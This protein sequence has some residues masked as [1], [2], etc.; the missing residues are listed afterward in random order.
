MIV[1]LNQYQK[2]L[3]SGGLKAVRKLPGCF[4]DLPQ[5]VPESPSEAGYHFESLAFDALS[6]GHAGWAAICMGAA[7]EQFRLAKQPE[8]I[9]RSVQQNLLILAEGFPPFEDQSALL[10]AVRTWARLRLALLKSDKTE[11]GTQGLQGVSPFH[12]SVLAHHRWWFSLLRTRHLGQVFKCDSVFDAY[13]ATLLERIILWTS[14]VV[15]GKSGGGIRA[16]LLIAILGSDEAEQAVYLDLLNVRGL[17]RQSG[18][19]FMIPDGQN[20]GSIKNWWV[21][22]NPEF[23]DFLCFGKELGNSWP[24]QIQTEGKAA[25]GILTRWTKTL[26]DVGLIPPVDI[27]VEATTLPSDVHLMRQVCEQLSIE[28]WTQGQPGKPLPMDQ[29]RAAL[30]THR[31]N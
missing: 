30:E 24:S 25:K 28:V 18:L 29:L 6:L 2:A 22:P 3:S 17:L 7:L 8:D 21:R 15:C 13:G 31:R 1:D 14:S 9:Q 10:D 4:S 27:A 16:G 26:I 19:L 12:P 20:A 23:Q 5:V 11:F